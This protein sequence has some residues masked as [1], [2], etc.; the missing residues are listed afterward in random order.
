MHHLGTLWLAPGF[1]WQKLHVFLAT[2]LTESEKKP[3]AEEHDLVLHSLPVEEFEQKMRDGEARDNCTLSA[4]GLYLL[5][6]AKQ[7]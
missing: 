7:G 6:K 3:D 5:W 1:L 4:W 2:G